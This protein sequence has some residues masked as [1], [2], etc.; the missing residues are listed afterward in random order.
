M[1]HQKTRAGEDEFFSFQLRVKFVFWQYSTFILIFE[2]FSLSQF[3]FT[4]DDTCW[5]SPIESEESTR[6]LQINL[7]QIVLSFYFYIRVQLNFKLYREMNPRH[8]FTR[9]V[10]YDIEVISNRKVHECF[11]IWTPEMFT[12][13]NLRTFYEKPITCKL[14]IT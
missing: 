7:P 4:T 12:G 2:K 11:G 9:A 6:T 3:S 10:S 14:S 1:E 13:P 8:I 5:K